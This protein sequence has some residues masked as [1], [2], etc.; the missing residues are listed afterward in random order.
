MACIWQGMATGVVLSLMLGTVFFSLIRNSILFGYRTGIYIAAG[1]I[2]CDVMFIGLALLST[3]FAA[4]LKTYQTAVSVT[5]GFILTGMGAYMM[6][7]AKPKDT[8][9]KAFEAKS[10]N[11]FYYMA[12]GFLLNV[13]NPVN[14][15]SW[16]AIS[17]VL[18]LK[19][20]YGLNQ[21]LLYFA[22]CLSSIFV[23]EFGIAYFASLLKKYIS[24]KVIQRINLISGLVFVLA[25]I[26]LF[27]EFF[28]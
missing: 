8:E 15:F 28:K 7:H 5:A 20:N 22:A 24:N 2:L 13:L 23:M 17:S 14:F 19:M 10:R 25:G 26:R 4:F 9:G 3:G 16:L 1:V 18:T 12:N 27:A 11:P 21:Q 6:L